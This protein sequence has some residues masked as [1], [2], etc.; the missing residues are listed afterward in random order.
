MQALLGGVEL[1]SNNYAAAA[2]AFGTF[3]LVFAGTGAETTREVLALAGLGEAQ[4]EALIPLL[5]SIVRGM[6][7]F[8]WFTVEFG[9]MRRPRGGAGRRHQAEQEQADQQF[10]EGEAA[11][12]TALGSGFLSHVENGWL[13]QWPNA[14]GRF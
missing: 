14:S 3:A 12:G 13:R 11:V 2:E 8:F 7:R 4:I 5:D 9:L 10:N 6:A 1:R